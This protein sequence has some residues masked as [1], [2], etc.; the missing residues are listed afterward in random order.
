MINKIKNM[1][2]KQKIIASSMGILIIALIIFI[3]TK[4]YAFIE[5][6]IITLLPPAPIEVSDRNEFSI[7]VVLSDLGKELYPAAS[8]TVGFDKNK[9]EFT[10]TKLGTMMTYG[11]TTIDGNSFDI[12]LWTCNVERANEL[13]EINTMYMDMTGGKYAYSKSGFDKETKNVVLR[14]GF[15]LKDSAV[16]GEVYNIKIHDAVIA[17]INGDKDNTSLA[18]NQDTL[19]ARSCKIVVLK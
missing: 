19:R 6:P 11:D 5:T 12:P 17:A 3:L 16:K 1:S 4:L 18:T 10:G 9:L 14:L 13:G 15:K 2:R 7:D 8:L